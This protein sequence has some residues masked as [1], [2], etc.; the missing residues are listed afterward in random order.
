MDSFL[1]SFFI[2]YIQLLL[3]FEELLSGNTGSNLMFFISVV[4]W[5]KTINF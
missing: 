4:K 5:I 2:P 3:D 1:A